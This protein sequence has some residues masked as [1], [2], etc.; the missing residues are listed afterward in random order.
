[1]LLWSIL[2]LLCC[3]T[4]L[5]WTQN[6]FDMVTFK[7]ILPYRYRLWRITLDTNNWSQWITLHPNGEHN[8]WDKLFSPNLAKFYLCW[9]FQ[10]EVHNLYPTATEDLLRWPMEW[11][12]G[13]ISLWKERVSYW[14]VL[15]QRA[16]FWVV[17]VTRI[18]ALWSLDEVVNLLPDN[19]FTGDMHCFIMEPQTHVSWGC[20]S[21]SSTFP[22]VMSMHHPSIQSRL[23]YVDGKL[24][25]LTWRIP[26]SICQNLWLYHL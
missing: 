6:T 9:G 16:Y 15:G 18:W 21:S 3:T 10:S 2:P 14:E 19:N 11:K 8:K 5:Y 22:H 7:T 1:M 24:I 4:D 25:L 17:D 12:C 20:H 26:K 13:R 23:P